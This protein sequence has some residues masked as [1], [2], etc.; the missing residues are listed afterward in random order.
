MKSIG[1]SLAALVLT[2]GG[3]LDAQ[4]AVRPWILGGVHV[5][6]QTLFYVE[7]QIIWGRST[8]RFFMKDDWT[9]DQLGQTDELSHMFVAYTMTQEVAAEWQWAGFSPKKARAVAA[10]ESALLA[11]VVEGLDAF[12][13]KQ[14]F[15]VSDLLFGYGGVGASLWTL[16]HRDWDLKTS[17][18][19]DVFGSQGRL[20]ARTIAQSDNS[21]FWITYRPP[22]GFGTKQP[23]SLG[24]GHSTRRAS[25]GV[26][27][28]RE[29]HLG[30]GTTLPDVV[31]VFSPRAARVVG[32]LDYYYFN[33]NL[34]ATLR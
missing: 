4:H 11:T 6:G 3:N 26:S 34:S 28:V 25:D 32:I 20:F 13:P 17:V 15:G 9:H 8:G 31:R 1:M 5:V 24:L 7:T 18:K 14:G 2:T 21:I 10:F 30:V 22:L 19:S 12:N 27:P 16:G 29:L 33:L 23:F